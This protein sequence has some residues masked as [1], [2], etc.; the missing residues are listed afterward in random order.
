MDKRNV[1]VGGPYDK[2]EFCD[3]IK[4]DTNLIH[5]KYY[6]SSSTLSHL[7]SQAN[8]AAETFVQDEDFRIRL[9]SK[10]PASCKLTDPKQRP[11]VGNYQITYAIATTKTIP[12]ELPFF[13][14][15]TLKNALKTLRAMNFHVEL[16]Q[17]SVDPALLKTA[18]CKPN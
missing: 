8:V 17:I 1:A 3:L 15:I 7:F 13:S 14:K 11:D 5:V 6:R 12:A 18:K 10:L 2:I 4:D 16:A 9:N